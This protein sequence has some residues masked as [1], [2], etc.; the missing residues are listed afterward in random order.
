MRDL[1]PST[2][3]EGLVG[4]EASDPM[5]SMGNLMDVMLVFAC[6][7]MLALVSYWN[8]DL[9]DVDTAAT[10]DDHEVLDGELEAGTGELEGSSASLEELG[11]VYRDDSTGTLYVIPKND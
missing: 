5:S 4:I 10:D 8:V 2:L 3:D 1:M 6:G 11:T 9:S 7:L